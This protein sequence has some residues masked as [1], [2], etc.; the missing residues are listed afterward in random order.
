MSASIVLAN[1]M[2]SRGDTEE[3]LKVLEAARAKQDPKAANVDRAMAE[4]YM[5][6]GQAEKAIESARRVVAATGDADGSLKKEIVRTY[7]RLGKYDEADK[8][9]AGLAPME[10]KDVDVLICHVLCCR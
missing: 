3:A 7:L 1:Y 4:F 10:S 9:Y 8:E 2:G 5:R 6:L